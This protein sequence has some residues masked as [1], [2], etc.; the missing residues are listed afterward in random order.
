MNKPKILIYDLETSTY[1]G[2]VWGKY[3]QNVLKF[4]K[5]RQILSVSYKWLGEEK[6]HTVTRQ[7]L[8]SDKALCIRLHK[9]FQEADIVVAHNGNKF[10]QKVAKARFIFNGLKPVKN[11]LTVDTCAAARREF[12]FPGNSLNDLAAFFGFGSK[13]PTQGIGLWLGCEADDPKAWDIMAKY[14]R[15]DVTLLEKVYDKLRPWITNHPNIAR[16][17]SGDAAGN[18]CTNCA[19]FNITKWGVRP[20]AAGLQQRWVCKDCSK[21]FLTKYR[22]GC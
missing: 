7:G 22:K 12:D 1:E 4:T 6:V 20:T 14:N 18:E 19:S 15:H 5:Y 11:L 3:E 17:V 21:N 10:D 13:L 16:I 2:H 8:K 9:L